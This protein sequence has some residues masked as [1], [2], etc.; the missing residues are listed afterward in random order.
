MR[1]YRIGNAGLLL[2]IIS[3][4]LSASAYGQTAVTAGKECPN[5]AVAVPDCGSPLRTDPASL[6]GK[7]DTSH[8]LG[9]PLSNDRQ[10]SSLRDGN[11]GQDSPPL[12]S[13]T[14]L[15]GDPKPCATQ[16]MCSSSSASV[17]KLD[18]DLPSPT[19][20]KKTHRDVYSRPSTAN[21][22]FKSDQTKDE[23]GRTVMGH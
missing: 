1:A 6:T 10:A 4:V 23:R 3:F 2:L 19:P 11:A 5:T 14:L 21:N 18:S 17:N 13:N 7:R 12:M 8:S 9:E 15:S 20:L 22:S 16:V